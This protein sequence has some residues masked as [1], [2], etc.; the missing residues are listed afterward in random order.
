MKRSL[1]PSKRIGLDL[2]HS[3][4]KA[5]ALDVGPLGAGLRRSQVA[6]CPKPEGEGPGAGQTPDPLADLDQAFRS[7]GGA[8]LGLDGG[9]AFYRWLDLPRMQGLSKTKK[10]AAAA[11][12]LEQD[13][14]VG[15]DR[16]TVDVGRWL[17]P[18]R[19][20][21]RALAFGLPRS[22]VEDLLERL[23]RAGL[24]PRFV[25][26]DTL[27]LITAAEAAGVGDGVVLD[28]GHVKTT[29]L[30]FRKGRIA[31]LGFSEVAGAGLEKHLAQA[32]GL[33]PGQARERK[34]S[35]DSPGRT[36][37]LFGPLLDRLGRETERIVKAAFASLEDRPQSLYL[38]GG[39]SRLPGLGSFLGRR[40]SLELRELMPLAK[41]V[42]PDLVAAVGLALAEP[43][44]D[45]GREFQAR[46]S[47][48]RP[49]I[50]AL[51]A[52]ALALGLGWANLH[53]ALE[54]RRTNLGGLVAAEK[55]LVKKAVPNLTRIVSPLSQLRAEKT[56]L[57]QELESL[58]GG[59]GGRVIDL[60]SDL[61]RLASAQ[62]I[63]L[64]EVVVDG[65]KITLSG[66]AGSFDILSAFQESLLAQGGF[67]EVERRSG[68]M[69]GGSAGVRFSLE[70]K[71]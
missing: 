65:G 66:T 32:Q 20:G 67:A 69:E 11:F 61:E 5:V 57:E 45:L 7:R 31:G 12:A 52:L 59:Q 63:G 8:G 68:K 58:K 1:L 15:L 71:R 43:G 9:R 33:E 17:K 41:A 19:E 22:Q 34:E 25:S 53:Q 10:R 38:C 55:A 26:L 36:E 40:L 50:M 47:P 46:S 48:K 29:V 30:C 39:T 23:G 13:L 18:T 3:A 70:I 64:D 21:Q 44:F 49:L 28:L 37:E 27:G 42:E 6:P 60:L 56:R 24:A 4:L 62:K 16:L 51:V 14:P 2:G 35:L 54:Q